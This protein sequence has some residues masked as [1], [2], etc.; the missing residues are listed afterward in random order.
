MLNDHNLDRA[1]HIR[2]QG[3]R[4]FLSQNDHPKRQKKFYF[5]RYE[6]FLCEMHKTMVSFHP[7]PFFQLVLSFSSQSK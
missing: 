6:V 1:N 3:L 7:L 4:D 2:L 5:F